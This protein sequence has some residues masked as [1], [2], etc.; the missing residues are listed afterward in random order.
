MRK[1]MFYFYHLCE[2][3]VIFVITF[4]RII[5]G[6]RR[7]PV[8]RFD[9]IKRK[10]LFI[11]GNGPSYLKTDIRAFANKCDVLCVNWFPVK[12]KIFWELKPRYVCAID[13]AFFDEGNPQSL[14]YI[15]CLK[16]VDWNMYVICPQGKKFKINNSNIKYIHLNTI[17]YTKAFLRSFLCEHNLVNLGMHNVIH[18]ALFT[19]IN[20]NYKRILLSGVDYSEMNNIYIN[21]KNEIIIKSTH[22][23]G[24]ELYNLTKSGIYKQA[25]FYKFFYYNYLGLKGFCY[26][27]EFA[28]YKGIDIYN[29]VLD[30]NIDSF[31]KISQQ[32][33]LEM[34]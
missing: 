2:N 7:G 16:K 19:G 1:F 32:E 22:G 10:N 27:E 3:T 14:L 12:E 33:V 6:K 20:L 28:K 11:I 8:F 23:Y 25:E 9:S 15:D 13:P 26:I 5:Y 4:L 31:V 30:S 21:E 17:R 29:L 24:D 18:A 34:L